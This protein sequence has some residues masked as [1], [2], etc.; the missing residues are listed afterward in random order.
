M[1]PIPIA[2]FWLFQRSDICIDRSSSQGSSE[3]TR[4]VQFEDKEV[5]VGLA[6]PKTPP[7]KRKRSDEPERGDPGTL[8]KS[9]SEPIPSPVEITFRWLYDVDSLGRSLKPGTKPY[10]AG[11]YNCWRI[12]FRNASIEE[13]HVLNCRGRRIKEYLVEHTSISADEVDVERETERYRTVV[14]GWDDGCPRWELKF[15]IR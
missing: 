11:W 15:M 6:E 7:A 5:Q 10:D 1:S 2:L 13:V 9:R 4:R 3:R 14:K 12:D 8:K